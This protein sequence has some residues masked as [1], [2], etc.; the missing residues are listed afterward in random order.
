MQ[1]ADSEQ[2]SYMVNKRLVPRWKKQL[3][4]AKAELEEKT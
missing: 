1:V 4:D 3:E 2:E